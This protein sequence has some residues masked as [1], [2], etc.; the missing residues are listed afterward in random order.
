MV[1]VLD[2]MHIHNFHYLTLARVKMSLLLELI[3]V[4]QGLT[5]KLDKTAITAEAKYS[6]NFTESRKR[7]VLSLHCNGNNSFLFVNATQI[8]QLKAKDSEIKSYKLCLSNILT[9]FTIDNMK[10]AGLTRVVKFCCC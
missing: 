5:Q 4:L 1:M 9:D 6:I 2:S 8:S 10:K 3:I 7:F